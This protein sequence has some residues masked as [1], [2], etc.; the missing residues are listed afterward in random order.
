MIKSR[1]KIRLLRLKRFIILFLLST[2]GSRIYADWSLMW[3]DEFNGKSLNTNTWVLA[4]CT[5]ANWGSGQLM[6][7]TNDVSHTTVSNGYVAI[8]GTATQQGTNYYIASAR[9][10]SIGFDQCSAEL[11]PESN[12]V[13]VNGGASAG[14]PNGGAAVE[15]RA[16][17]PVG[18]G[19]WPAVW[20][21]PIPDGGGDP[22]WSSP[23]YGPSPGSG[24]IDILETA[25]G[26]GGFNSNVIDST[27]NH[28]IWNP[29]D[30][31][32]QW[33]VYRFNWFTNQM[34]FVVDGVTNGT[35]S[36]WTPP[37]DFSYPAPFN[38]PFFI[39]I[40]LAVGGDYVGNPTPAQCAASLPAELDVDYIRI[41]QQVN[42][43]LSVT[44]TNENVV[45]SWLLQPA[46]WV[47]EEATSLYGPWALVPLAQYQTNQNTILFTIQQ[48][49]TD[50]MFYRLEEQ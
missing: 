19:L 45:L 33:H 5:S 22:N 3:S 38:I 46:P 2:S 7:Y 28:Y 34:Q 6:N 47:L 30:D 13:T 15:F 42:P 9:M 41:Y 43:L 23:I 16:R 35:F 14:Y 39:T 40:N 26:N 37:A 10:V 20:L 27:G 1:L 49:F 44:Q 4:D 11:F 48:P 8:K 50:I 18:T 24:E 32:T 25:G 36:G 21:L 12:P 29:I 31:V 17:V